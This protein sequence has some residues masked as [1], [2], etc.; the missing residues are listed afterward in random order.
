[1]TRLAVGCALLAASA[2]SASASSAPIL[3]QTDGLVSK[4][5]AAE[6]QVVE[7]FVNK[8]LKEKAPIT[9]DEQDAFKAVEDMYGY[10]KA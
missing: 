3:L 10:L 8:F 9:K 2:F 5:V 4:E 6:V 7:K 1:M